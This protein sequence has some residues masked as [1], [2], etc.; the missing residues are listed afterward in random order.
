M[1]GKNSGCSR[2]RGKIAS[3]ASNHVTHGAKPEF[4]GTRHTPT[5]VQVSIASSGIRL[6]PAPFVEP[7]R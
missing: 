5:P 3:T 4:K 6:T 7:H 1:S 2:F